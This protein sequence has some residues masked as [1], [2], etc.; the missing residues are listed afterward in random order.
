MAQK[1]I[2]II[3]DDPD[4]CILAKKV[5]ESSGYLVLT[6]NSADE[7]FAIAFERAPHVVITDLKMPKKTGFDFLEMKNGASHLHFVPTLVM[8]ALKDKSSVLKALA[9]GASDYVIKPFQTTILIQ[10]VKKAL[11]DKGFPKRSLTQAQEHSHHDVQGL[12]TR[13]ERSLVQDRSADQR[14]S[15]HE[16]FRRVCVSR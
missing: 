2:L 3:D 9:M 14:G 13:I 1:E 8:S 4:L 10:K 12:D 6:A 15:L 5:L 16:C 11:Q 7:G